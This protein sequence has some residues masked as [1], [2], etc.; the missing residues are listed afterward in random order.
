[1]DGS[2][3]KRADCV[4]V[5]RKRIYMDYASTTPVALEVLKEMVSYFSEKFGNPSSIHNEGVEA[6]RALDDARRRTAFCI[7]ARPSEIIFTSGGT[8]SNNLSLRGV[9]KG[10]KN[11]HI[12]TTN[13]EHSSVLETLK[14]LEK[15]GVSVTY[16]QIES[17]G[18]VDPKKIAS[19]LRPETA[20]IS[21]MLA[22]N[23][24]GTIQPIS[25]IAREIG[26]FRNRQ[27]ST[28]NYQ[29]LTTENRLPI[30]HVDASQ[31][32]LYIDCSPSRLG[33]DLI[34]FDAHK[35]RGPKGIGVLYAR[36]GTPLAHLFSGG[37][38]ERGIRPTTENVPLVVGM[39]KAFEM[40]VALR[41]KESKRLQILRSYLYSN[42]LKNIRTTIM[43]NGDLENRL[44]NNI[45]FSVKGLDAEFAILKLDAVGIACS[46]KSSCLGSG[47]KSYVIS[48]LGGPK[49]RAS[50]S[51]RFT[52]GRETTKADVNYLLKQLA[53]I[54][55]S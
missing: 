43:W 14:D 44:P 48:A 34:T 49:W 52:F 23:E 3:K 21:V 54:V 2:T 40:A 36:T 7:G 42:V 53:K 24:I 32:P 29:L 41:E 50:S 30:F 46:T 45:N 38:Q 19:A 16:V 37:G 8:E 12:V 15:G 28:I 25:K 31:A 5:M 6:K 1:M 47:G 39:A 33:A 17:N 13:I 26:D 4:N 9:V 55:N 35:M 22:N 51:L 20:L 10:I 11:A 27:L 18:I